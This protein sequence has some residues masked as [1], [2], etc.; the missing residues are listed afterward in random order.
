MNRTELISTLRLLLQNRIEEAQAAI[1][2]TYAARNE[3]TK[4]SAGDKHEVGRAMI[5]QELDKQE[6]QLSKLQESLNALARVPLDRKF[7]QVA[8]GSLVRTDQGDYLI[9]IGLG[10]IRTGTGKFFAISIDS[11]IGQVLKGKAVGDV[12]EFNGRKIVIEGIE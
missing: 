12:V 10:P 2:S 5:Q 9:A 8:F 4:S 6:A 1:A 3:D 11:P 7:D